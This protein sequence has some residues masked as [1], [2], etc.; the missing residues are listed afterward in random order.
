MCFYYKKHFYQIQLVS[1]SRDTLPFCFHERGGGAKVVAYLLRIVYLAALFRTLS[2]VEMGWKCR[3]SL[4]IFLSSTSLFI[5]STD[6]RTARSMSLNC[7]QKPPLVPTSLLVILMLTIL[8]F[9]LLLR[10]IM[11]VYTFLTAFKRLV[12]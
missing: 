6:L 3:P 1:K 9:F 2:I 4:F 11:L 7:S 8:L 10:R 5:T 12:A